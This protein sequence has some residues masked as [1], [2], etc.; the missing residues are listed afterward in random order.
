MCDCWKHMDVLIGRSHS[1]AA[2]EKGGCLAV[3]L[4]YVRIYSLT[5]DYTHTHTQRPAQTFPRCLSG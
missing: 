4:T 3:V 1:L 5:P 2:R